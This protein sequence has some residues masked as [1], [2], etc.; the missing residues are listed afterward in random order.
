MT[1][2]ATLFRFEDSYAR[3]VPGL[4]VPWTAA[5]VPAPELL[6][7]NEELAAELG[8]DPA[9]LREPPGVALLVG[10]VPTGVTTVAQAYAGHQFGFYAPRL[11]DGRALLLGEV[12]DTQGRRRDLHLKGSGRTPFSRG[13][14]GKA[15]VGPMLREY[16]IGEAMHGLGIPTTRALAVVATGER[17]LRERALP[18]AVLARV[19]ASH[20]RVGTFQYAAASG[21]RDRLR[22]LAD[23]AIARHYPEAAGAPNRYLDLFR[24]VTQAQA[25]LVARW[26]LV[27]FVHGVMNTDNTTISGETI[28]YGPCAFMDAFDPATVFSSIDEGGRY[29][30]GHQPRILQW[31]LARLAEALLPLFDDNGEAAVEAAT[32]VL[33]G[34]TD[35]YARHWAEGMAAKL[36]LA[37]PDR[38]LAEDLLKLLRSQQ[39][40]F[41]R[42]FRALS[43]GTARTLFTE[44]EPFDAWAVR[45]QV[46]LPA[47]RAAVAAAMDRVN[48]VYIPRN[49]RVEEALAAAT[50]GELGP[51]RRLVDVVS[52]PFEER[53]GL[54]DYAGPAPEGR[55]PYVTYCG[56]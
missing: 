44:P 3:E 37:A 42:F 56:T 53:P 15:V 5:S 49:H 27:G 40:D 38:D 28:D 11:G 35:A 33:D 22:A 2:T 50:D 48:P 51:F 45:R 46:L 19:A 21:D 41:T 43:A 8:V 6:V 52:R 30:Y 10:Q 17:V 31:N 25:S 18:G 36:G 9:E 20:L 34:F 13:A 29:A 14:D 1:V 7:L 26:M 39:V 55:A 12:I 23:Y 16:L 4:S 32:E 47:D 54:A 24:R